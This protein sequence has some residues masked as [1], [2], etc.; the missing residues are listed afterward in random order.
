MNAL[1]LAPDKGTTDKEAREIPNRCPNCGKRGTFVR[2]EESGEL[3]C[4]NCGFVL[5]EKEEE[6]IELPS[7]EVAP[8]GA[9]PRSS[10]SQPDMGL[11][12]VIGRSGRDASNRQISPKMKSTVERIRVWDTRSRSNQTAY[13]NMQEAFNRI[14]TLAGRLSVGDEVV[15]RASYIYR[16]AVERQLTRGRPIAQLSAAALYA[17][18]RDMQVPRSLKDVAV[19]GNVT[20][21]DLSRSY[22]TLLTELDIR[23]PVEDPVRSVPKVGSAIGASPRTVRRA[24]DILRMAESKGVTAGKDPMALAGAALYIASHLEGEGKTQ[25]SV[26]KAAGV[27]EV[28]IRAEYKALKSSLNL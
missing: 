6:G 19:A 12:T 10:I 24:Q 8:Q 20:V 7:S 22:R 26:A 9:R 13:R 23:M 27:T 4:S 28:T 17:A 15:E 11:E 16:K 2:D 3:V 21:K 18:C 25:K 14:R 1:A 5:R